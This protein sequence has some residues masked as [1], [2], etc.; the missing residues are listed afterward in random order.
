MALL[1]TIF[2]PVQKIDKIDADTRDRRFRLKATGGGFLAN[3]IGLGSKAALTADAEGF[4]LR[5]KRFGQEDSTFVPRHH[6]ASTV[7]VVMMKPLLLLFQGLFFTLVGVGT[8]LLGPNKD[9]GTITAGILLT[10][11]IVSVVLYIVSRKRV[12]LGVIST[13]GTVET[14]KLKVNADELTDILE[15]VAI[16]ESLVQDR[17]APERPERTERPEKPREPSPAAEP[18]RSRRSSTADEGDTRRIACPGCGAHLTVSSGMAGKKV[19]CSAC[20][21]VM[22]VPEADE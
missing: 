16:L 5:R 8:L 7:Y 20:Q 4:R 6:I 12:I 15:G 2:Q 11:G 10:V 21:E 17:A 22:Q 3:L 1:P 14:I 19:R 13:G 9:A 18:R